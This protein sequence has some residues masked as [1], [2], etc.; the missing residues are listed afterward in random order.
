MKVCDK[1]KNYG[2][3]PLSNSELLEVLL[4]AKGA[5]KLNRLLQQYDLKDVDINDDSNSNVLRIASLDYDKLKHRG[6]LTDLETSRIMAAV[7]LG[8]RIACAGKYESDYFSSASEPYKAA[9]YLM[10][11]MR[12]LDHEIVVVLALDTKNNIIGSK[13][14]S[15][16]SANSA[17]VDVRQIFTYAVLSNAAS[18]V[19]AHNHVSGQTSPSPEDISLTHLIY[20]ASIVMNI[21]L[22]D[23]IIIGDGSYYSFHEN[24]KLIPET[25]NV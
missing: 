2:P 15:K 9:Q 20:S 5:V 6:A 25:K 14:I 23:H 4:G 16:G 12:Y 1:L 7:E 24:G 10:P 8:I 21:P 18:I 11:K 19:L 3:L 17:T 13:I 22:L